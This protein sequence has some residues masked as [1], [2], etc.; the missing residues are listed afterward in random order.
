MPNFRFISV[1]LTPLVSLGL[2][3]QVVSQEAGLSAP[4]KES[5]NL[6]PDDCA[7]F[8][9]AGYPSRLLFISHA[10]E[11][12]AYSA[13]DG[14]QRYAM[15]PNRETDKFGQ[16]ASQDILDKSGDV[17]ELRLNEPSDK[18]KFVLYDSGTLSLPSP[19]GWLRIESAQGVS[20]CNETG[21]GSAISL[22]ESSGSFNM[23]AWLETPAEL[24]KRG[25]LQVVQIEMPQN[26]QVLPASV[27][28]IPPQ[29]A[30]PSI[31]ESAPI[32]PPI[33]LE[34]PM[35]PAAPTQIAEAPVLIS[36]PDP[37]AEL[38]GVGRQDSEEGIPRDPLTE[39]RI[40]YPSKNLV[41]R[42]C[43]KV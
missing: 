23:P 39:P 13:Q 35:I 7:L 25:T 11:Q 29:I 18:S 19:D 37:I 31:I 10:S 16:S 36:I 15:K 41:H 43:Y 3:T 40:L 4:L 38:E 14:L 32:E 42:V 33:D 30:E 5:V 6:A 24:A 12:A 34:P 27:V 20:A 21:S 28:T 17:L 22:D 8:V 1:L 26:L 2:G 9:W